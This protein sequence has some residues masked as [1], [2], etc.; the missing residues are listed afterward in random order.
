VYAAVVGEAN[1]RILDP[2]VVELVNDGRRSAD[3]A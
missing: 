2:I 3:V 1:R